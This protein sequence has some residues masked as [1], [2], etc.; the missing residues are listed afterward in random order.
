MMRSHGFEMR[1]VVDA[2]SLSSFL[3]A[4]LLFTPRG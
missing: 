1:D 3:F 4:D 2:V